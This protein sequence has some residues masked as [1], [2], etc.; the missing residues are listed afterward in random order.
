VKH[1]HINDTAWTKS[2]IF[3]L[4]ER[5]KRD[6]WHEFFAS[7]RSDTTHEIQFKFLAVAKELG[8]ETFARNVIESCAKKTA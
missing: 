8:H 1:R 7:L 6:D 2:A 4:F 5:G 3:S